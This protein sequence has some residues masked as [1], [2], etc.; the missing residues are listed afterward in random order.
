[1]TQITADW[2]A[3]PSAQKVLTALTE[4]DHQALFVG[5]CVRNALLDRP[6]HDLDIATD[7]LPETTMALA[8][9]AGL[10]AIPTG[11]THGTITVLAEGQA[12]EVT[13]FRRDVDTDGRHASVAFSDRPEEDARRRDFTMN[14]LYADARGRVIDP[15][16]GLSD[17]HAGRVRFIGEASQRI[18]EDY[19]RILRFFRFTAYY[20]DPG[21]GIDEEGLA[22]SASG[23][24]GLDKVSPERIGQE[25]TKLLTAHDPAPSVAAMAA[26]GV[27]G[28]VLPGAAV[29]AIAPLVALEGDAGAT[30][31]ALRR[32]A[33]M[34]GEAV[35]ERFR[36]SRIEARDLA[37]LRSLAGAPMTLAEIAYRHGAAA[38]GDVCLI[39]AASLGTT[40]PGEWR[41]DIEKGATAEFPLKATDLMPALAGAELGNV[42]KTAEAAWIGSGFTLDREALLKTAKRE[43]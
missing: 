33:V 3:W 5:G 16:G 35:A 25:M 32:L 6:V 41:S 14:A 27:L 40:L 24:E 39:R 42:L 37:M 15:L 34:G 4:A 31:S 9:A 23:L 11:I 36:L 2:L 28:T 38:A 29:S 43:S 17:L 1:M 30:P 8:E 22:A 12:F 18:A 21:H 20:G 13:T 7:A 10:K 19:L 26:S